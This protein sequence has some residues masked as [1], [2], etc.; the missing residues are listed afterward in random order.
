MSQG[1]NPNSQNAFE[2][3]ASGV[4]K[5]DGRRAAAPD[6]VRQ[7]GE[8]IVEMN[9]HIQVALQAGKAGGEQGVLEFGGFAHVH[10][11]AVQP[12]SGAALG[13]EQLAIQRIVDD[14]GNHFVFAGQRERDVPQRK[15][16]R[17]VGGAVE[18]ID[19]PAQRRFQLRAPA[20][21]GYDPVLGKT[22]AQAL[23][24]K[25]LAGAVGGGH[26]IESAFQLKPHSAMRHQQLS[27]L[28]RDL[29]RGI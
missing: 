2:P 6:A 9:I 23:D 1:F 4:G 18:R 12:R 25:L 21:F 16:V 28:A 26:Q 14:A 7:H 27:G 3:A 24:D 10:G 20:F 11:R 13:G 29:D 15:A 19:I 5:I 8:L 22:L 17:E